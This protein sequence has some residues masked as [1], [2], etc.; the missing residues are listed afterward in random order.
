MLSFFRQR[1]VM[2]GAAAAAAIVVALVALNPG[3]DAGNA[4]TPIA[5]TET[6]TIEQ[7]VPAFD[8]ASEL[9]EVEYLGQLMAVA[10]PGML[11][12]EALADLFF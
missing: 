1:T 3:Q 2:I 5:Q 8:P 11:T 9:E 10:D 6:E 12:D 7:E 4:S